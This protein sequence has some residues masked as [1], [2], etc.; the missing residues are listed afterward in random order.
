MN[1]LICWFDMD[2]ITSKQVESMGDHYVLFFP[3]YV[4]IEKALVLGILS[5]GVL[6]YLSL[7]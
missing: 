6:I 3:T 7:L 4:C 5:G 2:T 1:T